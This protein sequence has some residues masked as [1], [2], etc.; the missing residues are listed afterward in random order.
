MA[1]DTLKSGSGNNLLLSNDDASAKIEVK[2]DGTN[3]IT[4]SLIHI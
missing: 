1:T 2:E 3:E 4:L